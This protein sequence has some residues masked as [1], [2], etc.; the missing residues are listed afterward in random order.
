MH[1]YGTERPYDVDAA[2]VVAC[3]RLARRLV[4]AASRPVP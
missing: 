3:W 2:P 4:V 1:A